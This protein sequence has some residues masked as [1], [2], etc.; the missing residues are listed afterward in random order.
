MHEVAGAEHLGRHLCIQPDSGP[1]SPFP[2][3]I[4]F[5]LSSFVD[6]ST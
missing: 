2:L 3:H 5:V 6:P 4:A 1:Q